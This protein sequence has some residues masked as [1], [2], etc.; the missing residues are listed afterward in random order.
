MI[1]ARIITGSLLV[2]GAF[3]AGYH[4]YKGLTDW[5][6]RNRAAFGESNLLPYVEIALM[7]LLGVAGLWL[8]FK[9]PS[10]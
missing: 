9:K 6:N 1:S 8:L 2:L 7:L 10:A 5:Q 3:F 4:A